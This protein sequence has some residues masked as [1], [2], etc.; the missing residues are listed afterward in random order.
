MNECMHIS[1]VLS[2]DWFVHSQID[3]KVL[4]SVESS[5]DT[6]TPN[7]NRISP[8][9]DIWWTFL[10][11]PYHQPKHKSQNFQTQ[12]FIGHCILRW[13]GSFQKLSRTWHPRSGASL[14][15]GN[16]L[17]GLL[18]FVAFYCLKSNTEW[19]VTKLKK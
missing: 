1:W 15:L 14:P 12:R 9:G 16:C 7:F 11:F 19:N 5:E 4:G 8:R 17:P 2:F 13:H 18:S 6:F 3:L 10:Q